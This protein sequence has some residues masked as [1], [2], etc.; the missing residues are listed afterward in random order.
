MKEFKIFLK[1]VNEIFNLIIH[2]EEI[3]A[4]SMKLVGLQYS[5]FQ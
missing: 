1:D 5:F 2:I 3:Y 4:K